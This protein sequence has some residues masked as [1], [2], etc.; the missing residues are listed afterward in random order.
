MPIFQK[1]IKLSQ[2]RIKIP[3]Q[4]CELLQLEPS[5]LVNIYIDN[6]KIIIEKNNNKEQKILIKPKKI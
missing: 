6:G 4:I 3:H 5:Q 1:L 2:H